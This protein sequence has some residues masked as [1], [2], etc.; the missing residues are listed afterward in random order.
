MSDIIVSKPNHSVLKITCALGIEAELKEAFSYFVPNYKFMPKYKYGVWDGKI[1]MYDLRTRTFP[2]GLLFELC[3]FA[4]QR[5]YSI[6]FDNSQL[7]VN[8]STNEEYNLDISLSDTKGNPMSPRDYQLQS[9]NMA[10]KNKRQI[11]L[12]P[13]GS[14]KSLVIYMLMRYYQDKKLLLIVPTTALV[15]Q[16]YKDFQDY[17]Q[18]D[19]TYDVTPETVHRIYSG[20]DKN[21]PE[22]CNCTIT[23]WQSAYKLPQQ[24]FA[25]YKVVI[26]D[27]VHLF[28]AASLTKIMNNCVNA[29][30]RVGTT[31]TIDSNNSEINILTLKGLFGSIYK[32]TTTKALMDSNTLAKLNIDI[33]TLNHKDTIPSKTVY[34]MEMAHLVADQKRNKFIAKLALAQ[35]TN[36]LVLFNLVAK[37]GKPLYELI[38]ELNPDESRPIYYISGEIDTIVREEIR[39]LMETHPNAILVASFGSFSTGVNL[40]NLHNIIFAAPSKSAIRVLQSI[41]RGL[42][43]YKDYELK[44]FDIIDNYSGTNKKRNYAYQHGIERLK[45]YTA[46]KFKFKVYSVN[47]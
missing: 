29:G 14:G 37:H 21:P 30:I 33:L 19:D 8:E 11:I 24:W 44:L 22:S 5:D 28:K 1:Y 31:G 16:M 25:K 40:K 2:A 47:I 32:A 7:R 35:K 3:K 13:T 39:A 27:E 18:N 6:Q 9:V 34:Q 17:S 46:Q 38:C 26:G 23:T 41:G 45:I 4:K 15:E 43:K 42:R 10:I 20:H 12:S 36:T